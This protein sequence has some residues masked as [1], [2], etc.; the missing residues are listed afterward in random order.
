MRRGPDDHVVCAPYDDPGWTSIQDIDDLPRQLRADI[1]HFSSVYKDLDPTRCSEV[2]GSD[3]RDAAL[4][5]IEA[6]REQ[7]SIHVG[8]ADAASPA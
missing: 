5:T 6:A 8:T 2:T 3:D 4:A 7:Y 1:G